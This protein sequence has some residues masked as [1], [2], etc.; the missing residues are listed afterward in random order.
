MENLYKCSHLLHLL[1]FH[2]LLF[3]EFR[4]CLENVLIDSFFNPIYLLFCL[5]E[6]ELFL[7]QE[8]RRKETEY[9][10]KTSF[11]L[12]FP[13]IDTLFRHNLASNR[14]S[15]YHYILAHDDAIDSIPAYLDIFPSQNGAI[16]TSYGYFP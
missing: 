10:F 13:D 7:R 11:I 2:I 1:L 15:S 8:I 4:K 12:G 14:I 9:V 3:G 6:E 16:H 5:P